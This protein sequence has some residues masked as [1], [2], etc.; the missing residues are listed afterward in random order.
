MS[1]KCK[2]CGRELVQN[3]KFC[4]Y[5]GTE[6][7]IQEVARETSTE[8]KSM[9]K[10]SSKKILTFLGGGIAII[11][12]IIL[13][14]SGT[15]KKLDDYVEYE[16]KG[17]NGYGQCFVEF[18][19]EKFIFDNVKN[20]N[21]LEEYM[22]DDWGDLFN[23]RV[24]PNSNLK[25]GDKVTIKIIPNK[26]A[27]KK[28]GIKVKKYEKTFKVKDLEEPIEID[29]AEKF[30]PT[31]EGKSPRLTLNVNNQYNLEI[32]N[33]E[34]QYSIEVNKTENISN[35]DKLEIKITSEAPDGYAFKEKEFKYSVE[36]MAQYVLSDEEINK[37]EIQQ[38]KESAVK[39]IQDTDNYEGIFS[40]KIYTE[41]TKDTDNPER[42]YMLENLVVENIV[43][44]N[45]T[46]YVDL[47][48][49]RT[50]LPFECDV[51]PDPEDGNKYHVHGIISFWD[52][53]HDESGTF[54]YELSGM[55]SL[56]VDE[57][58]CNKTIKKT[59]YMENL[60]T[61]KTYTYNME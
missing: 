53:S 15:G 16:V 42:F 20:S 25:N 34:I 14:I 52:V 57:D 31:F 3:D 47:N 30:K 51:T 5:C 22:W 39:Y 18:D 9:N 26:S 37:E 46:V 6:T 60:D 12:A 19:E 48:S 36:G 44:H 35:G 7:T 45:P 54:S 24:E 10:N 13:L 1:N 50:L 43:F 61:Y 41:S 28:Y 17:S 29:V 21:S 40:P 58:D 38:L 23:Q 55:T 2:K 27:L 56:Y 32:D 59:F 49:A 33:T 4:P 8:T 11:I